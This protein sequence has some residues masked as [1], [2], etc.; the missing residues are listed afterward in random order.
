M[1]LKTVFVEVFHHQ[2]DALAGL[3]DLD[4]GHGIDTRD[5]RSYDEVVVEGLVDVTRRLNNLVARGVLQR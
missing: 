3:R 5:G 2:D 4:P 1:L